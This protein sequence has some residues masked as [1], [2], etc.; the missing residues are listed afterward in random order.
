M[1]SLS[2]ILLVHPF[3]SLASS[4]IHAEPFV[5]FI[6]L[7]VLSRWQFR[8]PGGQAISAEHISFLSHQGYDGL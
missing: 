7:T 3:H 2:H 4:Q 5:S 1:D 8:N 6:A